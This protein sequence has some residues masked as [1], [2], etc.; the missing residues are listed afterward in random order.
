MSSVIALAAAPDNEV[1]LTSLH[2]SEQHAC[3]RNASFNR[4]PGSR[5]LEIA[6][7]VGK[8]TTHEVI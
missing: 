4:D 1:K 8:P 5:G 2:V 7:D 3:I 6:Q